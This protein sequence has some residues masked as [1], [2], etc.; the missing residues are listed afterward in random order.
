MTTPIYLVQ[1]YLFNT[2]DHTRDNE[3]TAQTIRFLDALRQKE[4]AFAFDCWQHGYDTAVKE[5]R[6]AMSTT[7]YQFY[8]EYVAEQIIL[9]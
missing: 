7:F 8:E 4:K 6:G 1:E 5:E 3:W 9:C 2:F